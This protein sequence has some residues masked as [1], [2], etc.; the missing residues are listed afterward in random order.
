M[1]ENIDPETI[2]R[3]LSSG[4]FISQKIT[5]LGAAISYFIPSMTL[6]S[7]VDATKNRWKEYFHWIMKK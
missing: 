6:L 2:L 1:T 3:N 5:A 7:V 4:F